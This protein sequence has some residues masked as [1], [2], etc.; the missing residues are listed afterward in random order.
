[1][2]RKLLISVLALGLAVSGAQLSGVFA[3]FTDEA[4]TG[5]NTVTTAALARAVDVRLAK[6]SASPDGDCATV[7]DAAYADN[8]TSGFSLSNVTP[9]AA[10]QDLGTYC[11][12]N[13]GS[14]D[15]GTSYSAV[16]LV[17]V[18]DD[19]TGDEAAAGDTTCGAG[20]LGEVSRN[21]EINPGYGVCSSGGGSQGRVA[22]LR[23]ASSTAQTY[24]PLA[25]G[26]CRTV[27]VSFRYNPS[28]PNEALIA[29]SDTVTWKFAFQAV[30]T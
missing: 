22:N 3:A 24:G 5:T 26:E 15:T 13:F 12:K 6:A 30:Q 16:D 20:G 28:S 18:D 14:L 7:P 2:R 11:I 19:C 8:L 1:M 4:K 21:L 29:Q 27:A 17:D 10:F 23:T 25:A 9:S